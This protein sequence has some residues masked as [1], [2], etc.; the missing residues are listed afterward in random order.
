MLT[1]G[2]ATSA[3]IEQRVPDPDLV[4]IY[5]PK[6]DCPDCGGIAWV[7][8]EQTREHIRYRCAA[9]GYAREVA[10]HYDR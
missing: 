6:D 3:T 8:E 4:Q 7:C 1:A 5:W 10:D 2:Y 9:C